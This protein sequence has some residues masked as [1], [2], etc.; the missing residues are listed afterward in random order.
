[1]HDTGVTFVGDKKCRLDGV[2]LVVDIQGT[3]VGGGT[4]VERFVGHFAYYAL[5]SHTKDTVTSH[6]Q[7]AL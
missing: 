2:L 3:S 4:R 6:M 7:Y 5:K 1:M